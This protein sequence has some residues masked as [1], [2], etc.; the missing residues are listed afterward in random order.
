MPIAPVL[1][2]GLGLRHGRGWALRSASFRMDCMTSTPLG[3]YMPGTG[4]ASAVADLLAGL[5]RPTYGELRVLGEDMTTTRGRA[6]VRGRVGIARRHGR[7]Q[8]AFR[9][10]GLV[11]RGAKTARLPGCDRHLL[12]AAVLDRLSLTPWA[13]VPV[14][15]APDAIAR[16]A[17]LA[18]AAVH[19]PELLLIDGLLDGL[20]GRDL[21][22]LADAVRDLSR[23]T[24]VL[25]IGSDAG[26]LGLACAD[27]LTLS[28]GILVSA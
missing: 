26:A 25:A 8:P 18:A 10:R 20:T 22:A 16:R 17:R 3:I 7:P 27:V 6:A 14:R 4:A 19:Q 9:I 21:M 28:D 1:A 15:A 12:G 5:A 13:E 23:D 2:A 24:C 11:E